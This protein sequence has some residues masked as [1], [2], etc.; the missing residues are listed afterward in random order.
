ML[1]PYAEKL[2]TPPCL[3]LHQVAVRC[4]FQP[5]SKPG[6]AAIAL[7][8]WV[9]PWFSLGRLP[10][11][12]CF[13]YVSLFGCLPVIFLVPETVEPP[14]SF[15]FVS[16]FPTCSFEF[17]TCL[18][19]TC[20][21]FSSQVFSI[22]LP[23][24]MVQ[25]T[26][27]LASHCGIPRPLSCLPSSLLVACL[28]RTGKPSCSSP[29]DLISF[30]S[31]CLLFVSHV[32]QIF[33]IW[34]P[35]V[36]HLSP[37]CIQLFVQSCLCCR[38]ICLAVVAGLFSSSSVSFPVPLHL[39]SVCLSNVSIGAFHLSPIGFTPVICLLA[40]LRSVSP[41]PLSSIVF[42]FCLAASQNGAELG[43]YS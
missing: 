14:I 18:S 43:H 21:P 17:F 35:I 40:F 11:R 23:L 29:V 32:L 4:A 34:L 36:L 6:E 19:P 1:C 5:G 42:Q 30:V 20:L 31:T 3:Q 37:S 39:S 38:C 12:K 33:S 7:L 24:G 27:E 41:C 10:S 26:L 22:C 28:P 2:C 15:P 25:G 8:L 16:C 9:P 13:P